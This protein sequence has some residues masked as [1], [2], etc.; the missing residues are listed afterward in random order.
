MSTTQPSQPNLKQSFNSYSEKE[1]YTNDFMKNIHK[2]SEKIFPNESTTYLIDKIDSYADMFNYKIAQ[3]IFDTWLNFKIDGK[4]FC[5][6]KEIRYY[7]QTRFNLGVCA[8]CGK[9]VKFDEFAWNDAAHTKKAFRCK[10]CCRKEKLESFRK[11]KNDKK[12][13]NYL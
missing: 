3:R 10:D 11:H 13:L 7:I 12:I 5:S 6:K 1:F 9:M 4:Q 8:T 2:F